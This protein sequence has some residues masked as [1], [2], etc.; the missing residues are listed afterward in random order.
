M[1]L[2]D[3]LLPPPEL[4]GVRPPKPATS[5]PECSS[6]VVDNSISNL[7]RIMLY[8]LMYFMFYF[9]FESGITLYI[10]S[11]RYLCRMFVPTYSSNAGIYIKAAYDKG[12]LT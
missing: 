12:I 5:K 4:L 9:S 3:M 1:V 11:I 8:V 10:P 2:T 6:K 7:S